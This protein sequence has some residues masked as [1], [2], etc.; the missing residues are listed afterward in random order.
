MQCIAVAGH[1][2]GSVRLPSCRSAMVYID[3]DDLSYDNPEVLYDPLHIINLI[4]SLS[5]CLSPA[6]EKLDV[7]LERDLKYITGDIANRSYVLG[8]NAV[9]PLLPF[10]RLKEL[11]LELFHFRGVA[12]WLVPPSMTFTALVHLIQHCPR[13]HTVHMSFCATT[14]VDYD[15][16]PCFFETIPSEKI[17][18]LSVGMSPIGDPCAVAYILLRLLPKFLPLVRSPHT[19]ATAI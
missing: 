12:G 7:E 9:A 8:F 16:G 5:E 3:D 14:P 6:L 11:R 10:N 15:K 19:R 2:L 4:V 17:T 13:L 18:M 1:F